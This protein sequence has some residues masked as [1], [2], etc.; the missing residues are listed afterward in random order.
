MKRKEHE[1]ELDEHQKRQQGEDANK[2]SRPMVDAFDGDWSHFYGYAG[3]GTEIDVLVGGHWYVGCITGGGSSVRFSY[4]DTEGEEHR[5]QMEVG[6]AQRCVSMAPVGTHTRFDAKRPKRSN[7]PGATETELG[8]LKGLYARMARDAL[9]RRAT[10]HDTCCGAQ[11]AAAST[12]LQQAALD[13]KTAAARV[14]TE[15][16]AL[17]SVYTQLVKAKENT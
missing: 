1:N 14:E 4:A 3:L 2:Q 16:N 9:E 7:Y 13:V 5:G 12:R 8:N 6:D 11:A 15:L 10:N 17:K